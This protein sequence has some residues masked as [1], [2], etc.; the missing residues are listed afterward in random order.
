[1]EIRRT[2][3]YTLRL[4]QSK[5]NRGK[6][7]FFQ[8]FF[9]SGQIK[10]GAQGKKL[11]SK[12]KGKSSGKSDWLKA[13]SVQWVERYVPGAGWADRPPVHPLPPDAPEAG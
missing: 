6:T 3:V 4:N 11:A 7:R 8:A 2:R 13:G 5:Q 10:P 9:G 12:A 1:M